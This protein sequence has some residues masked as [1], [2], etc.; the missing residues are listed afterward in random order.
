MLEPWVSADTFLGMRALAAVTVAVV[1]TLSACGSGETTSP[2]AGAGASSEAT[3]TQTTQSPTTETQTAEAPAPQP[4]NATEIGEAIKAEIPEISTVTT[5][6]EDNDPNDKIGRPGGYVDGAVMFDSRAEPFDEEPGVD[7]GAFLEV[8][9]DEDAA[10]ERSEFIQGALKEADG[11]LGSEYHYQHE[12]FLLR[13]TG[14]IKPSEAEAYE[15]VFTA[16]F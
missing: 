5:I 11:V 13:V 16:Q 7:Q 3:P 1:L 15:A 9:P 4:K 2:S 8:W 12:G 14:V 10:T 6:T